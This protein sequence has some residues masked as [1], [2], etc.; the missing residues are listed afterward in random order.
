MVQKTFSGFGKRTGTMTSNNTGILE[1]SFEHYRI[2]F[3]KEGGPTSIGDIVMWRSPLT[4]QSKQKG[5]PLGAT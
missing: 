1:Q 2:S 4:A 3:L 5:Y